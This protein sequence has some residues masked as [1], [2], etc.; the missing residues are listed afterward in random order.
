MELMETDEERFEKCAKSLGFKPQKLKGINRLLPY[1]DELD[2]EST[3]IFSLFKEN[4]GKAILTKDINSES[5]LWWL[6][7]GGW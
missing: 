1:K 6:L 3:R 4:L 5:F 7:K 2:E